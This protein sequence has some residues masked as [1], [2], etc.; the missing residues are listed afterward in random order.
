V[1]HKPLLW[2]LLPGALVAALLA[3]ALA[4]WWA[5]GAVRQFHLEQAAIDLEAEARLVRLQVEPLVYPVPNPTAADSLCRA[6]VRGTPLRVSVILASGQVIADTGEELAR[7]EPHITADR[8]EVLAALR[9]ETGQSIRYSRTLQRS[10]LYVAI[11]VRGLGQDGPAIVGLVRAALPLSEIEKALHRVYMRIVGGALVAAVLVALAHAALGRRL[12]RRVTQR[13][14]SLRAAVDAWTR[15]ELQH[16]LPTSEVAEIDDLGEA[17][18]RMASEIDGR[19]RAVT[20]QRNELEAILLSMMEGV[21]AVDGSGRVAGMNDAGARM[22]GVDAARVKGKRV[23]EI[24]RNPALQRLAEQALERR[25]PLEGE[26][27]LHVVEDRF[28]EVRGAP[29]RDAAGRDAGVVLVI[30]D[31]TRLH[32]LE[33]MR[34]DFVANVSHE[35]RTPITA[36]QGAAEALADGP[37]GSDADSATFLKILI[38]QSGRLN[39]VIEDLL[40]LSRI[41]RATER[42]EVVLADAPL[43]PVLSGAAQACH[44]AAADRSIRLEVSCAPGL[45]A[46]VDPRLLESA[47]V[48]LIDNAIKYSEPGRAVRVSAGAEGDTI[49]IRVRDE[50]CGIDPLHHERIFERFYRVDASRSREAGG[51]GLGLAIVKHIVQAHGGT[52]RVQSAV[53][54]GS[55]FSI[56]LPQR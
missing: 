40:R 17:M 51:T 31:A 10:M 43:E 54:Q 39:A 27:V 16:R 15:G 38:R 28:L 48:N 46:R 8:V 7:L 56:V 53:G 26:V 20:D 12:S 50:G 21:L 18:S 29:W 14:R 5:C 52:V 2:H 36:I 9:G 42:S 23:E 13:L 11:P 19:L 34:R 6:L 33:A 25:E 44:A 49:V 41:E 55:T 37:L 3:L 45:R 22:L 4:A 32:R 47:V 1:R 35:L 30:H 24:L